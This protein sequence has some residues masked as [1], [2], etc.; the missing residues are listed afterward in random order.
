MKNST[1]IIGKALY[2]NLGNSKKSI[3][4]EISKL[5]QTNYLS[6]LKEK[7]KNKAFYEISETYSSQKDKFFL[8]F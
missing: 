5:D 1:Y 3:T 6:F 8:K 2:C 7:F 4:Q